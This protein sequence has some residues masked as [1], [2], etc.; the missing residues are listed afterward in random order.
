MK[1]RTFTVV[2]LLMSLS[3]TRFARAAPPEQIMASTRLQRTQIDR[4]LKHFTKIKTDLSGYSSEG[5]ELRIYSEH[6]VVRKIL[7]LYLGDYSRAT[8][9][10]YFAKGA[11]VFVRRIEK[12]YGK[13]LS[14]K[15]YIWNGASRI[16]TPA[17]NFFYFDK[18]KL[19]LWTYADA[20]LR[21]SY[22]NEGRK[23]EKR[24]LDTAR[25]FLEKANALLD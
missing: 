10:F 7:A 14:G 20:I 13:S 6:G 17:Y 1:I 8:E 15:P 22:S 18:G 21:A 3:S 23:K 25:D 5:G 24:L 12:F 4:D 9:E 16:P 11:L 2:A 19:V